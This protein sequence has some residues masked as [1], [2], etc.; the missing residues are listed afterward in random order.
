M[1]TLPHEILTHILSC[2]LVNDTGRPVKLH[3]QANR[4]LRNE[5]NKLRHPSGGY[6]TRIVFYAN[7]RIDKNDRVDILLVSRSFY[8]AAIE[9]F[10]RGN[11]FHFED[12]VHLDQLTSSLDSDRRR[13][14]Y[15]LV[16]EADDI[17]A[18]SDICGRP[19]SSLDLDITFGELGIYLE[20]LPLLARATLIVSMPQRSSHGTKHQFVSNVWKNFEQL[21]TVSGKKG[22]VL[23][24]VFEE[25][26][27]S[28]HF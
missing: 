19:R 8:F 1:Q 18:G 17:L 28:A 10:F 21:K 11:V 25:R 7:R 15:H 14:I 24:L 2:V 26:G 23:T 27:L 13:C 16:L 12:I 20:R 9:A 6:R 3:L 4:R 22:E 5:V